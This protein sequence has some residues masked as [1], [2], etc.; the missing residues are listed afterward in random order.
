MS[1]SWKVPLV[2]LVTPH[3]ELEGEL[4]E[5]FRAALGSARFIGGP[6]VDEFEQRFAELCSTR[7]C[8]G[9]SNGTDALRLALATAGVRR[10]DA[11]VTVPNTFIATT[12]AITQLGAWPEFVDVDPETYTMDPV[13]L[14][15]YLEHEC[16]RHGPR[17]HLTNKRTG[18]IVAAIVPVHLYGQTAD[19]DPVLEL[20]EE[21]GLIVVEDACQAHG[22]EYYSRR[23]RRWRRAGSM[24]RAAAFSFYPGKNLGACGEAGAITTNDEALAQQCRMLRDHG[25][26][27]KYVHEIEG[28]NNRL[29]A[30]QAGLL[31]V[32]LRRLSE[33]TEQRRECARYYD[34]LLGDAALSLVLPRVASWSRPVYHLYVVR[35]P[36][37]DRIREELA[38]V[39]IET[40]IHYPTLLHLAK[41]YASLGYR[42]GDYPVSEQAAAEVLSLPMFPGLSPEQQELVAAR[43]VD[44]LDATP[45]YPGPVEVTERTA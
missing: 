43:L 37:R 45:L 33:W 16:R 39:G 4:V 35:V 10:G 32:K 44:R 18:R 15:A 41:P 17:G 42:A 7:F 14:R 28:G 30:I 6:M 11:V 21:F 24:G 29:D 34:T 12:E 31:S 36:D 1:G 27:R 40:G 25:Q 20:A 26:S 13:K 9:V 23:Q 3:R 22:A 2:D 38:A 19:M 8:V 5:V